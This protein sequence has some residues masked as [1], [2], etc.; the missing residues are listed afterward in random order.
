VIWADEFD[1][2]AGAP[3][4]PRSWSYELGQGGNG[5]LQRYT[6]VN[7]AL[8]GDGS[9]AITARADLT[10][11][12]LVTKGRFAFTYGRVET[13]VRVP[14]GSGVWPAVWALGA[15]IDE[16][17]WPA[18]GEIDVMEH[19]G[20]DPRRAFGT[21]HCP[22]HAHPHGFGGAVEL[23]HDLADDFHVFAV[24]WHEQR[25]E[26]SLDG[27]AYHAATPADVPGGWVFDHPFYLLVNLALGGDLGGELDADLPQTL[28]VDYVRV[29]SP[30]APAP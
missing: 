29:T 16:A 28:L 5:E 17:G 11:A 22:G 20:Q 23:G 30:T 12:R 15:D 19:V 8:D 18:C 3:P 4:D 26:W 2:P 21:I 6:D 25:I 14:R 7:A 1:G 13:R 24:E 10:S 9:L 27:R